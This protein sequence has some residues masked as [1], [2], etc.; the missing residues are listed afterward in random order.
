L[1]TIDKDTKYIFFDVGNLFVKEEDDKKYTTTSKQEFIT[2][3]YGKKGI[4][5]IT[6]FK[7]EV[8]GDKVISVTEI[9]VN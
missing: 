3:L 4:P 7:V 5:R 1:F 2:F 6:P 9:F 8:T